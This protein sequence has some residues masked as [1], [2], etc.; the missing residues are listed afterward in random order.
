MIAKIV[1]RIFA[2]SIVVVVWAAISLT[3]TAAQLSPRPITI[4]APYSPG[5]GPDILARTIGEELRQ[6]WKQALM[7]L[8]AKT[9]FTRYSCR[10]I[11]PVAVAAAVVGVHAIVDLGLT[12]SGGNLDLHALLGSGVAQVHNFDQPFRDQKHKRA[13]SK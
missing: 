1:K 3:G 9:V 13:L 5:T 10:I 7:V 2:S 8:C 4:V 11:P 12:D 6:R